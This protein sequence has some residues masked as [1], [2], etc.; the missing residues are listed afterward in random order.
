M[1][2]VILGS[3]GVFPIFKNLAI[4]PR[5]RQVL[6]WKIHLDLYVIQ[7]YVVIVFQLVKQSAKPLGFLFQTSP[8][9][10]LCFFTSMFLTKVLVWIFEFANKF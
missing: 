10:L 6:E 4:V 9:D 2:Q 5:K 1:L 3:F 7:F 8:R